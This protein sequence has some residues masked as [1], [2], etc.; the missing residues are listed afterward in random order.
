VADF[1]ASEK[2]EVDNA[3]GE[4]PR[5]VGLT[6]TLS[7]QVGF[8]NLKM[9]QLERRSFDRGNG[10][11]S[12][13]EDG[14]FVYSMALAS[15]GASAL[16]VHFT[17]FNLPER[18]GVYLYTSDGQAFGPYTG[19][20]PLGDGEFW[21]NTV[22][23][24]YL[25]VQLRHIGP[26]TD[27][28]L[29]GTGFNV[30]GLAHIRPVFLAGLCGDNAS[31]V[32]NAVCDNEADPVKVAALTDSVALMQW[33]SG[34]FVYNCTGGLINDSDPAN[35]SNP[36]PYFLTANHC[37]SKGRDAKSLENFF[38][39][40]DDD[41]N[42]NDCLSWNELAGAITTRTLGASIVSTGRA[43]DYTLLQLSQAA[44]SG[45]VYLGW[46][47]TPVADT[48]GIDLFRVSH[49]HGSPQAY[50]EHTVD[51]GAPTCTS[52]PRGDR[53]YSR[54]IVGATEGGSSGSPVVN[55]AIQIVGQLSGACGTNLN[56]EC[57]AVNNATVDGAFA[58]Y[59]GQVS[60][61]LDPVA[62][63]VSE[64]TEVSCGDSIDNDCDGLVDGA[65]PDCGGGSGGSGAPG[66]A[67]LSDGDCQS[68]SCS[69]GKPSSRTCN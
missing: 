59:F 46:N 48:S 11:I 34:A 32:V 28:D 5:R 67:C 10:T 22:V 12:A 61:W 17:N 3:R 39:Y 44:P 27:E 25:V 1:S 45:S 36:V 31:C 50:S 26:A 52:W 54:D 9:S 49:P 24:D 60:Q 43:A 47:S 57:D 15:P 30:A 29:R 51:A 41:C 38:Q 53:I 33:I 64:P 8:G 65:D 23:G 55:G 4:D 21:S 37:I 6:K 63:T 66:D 68:N 18:T 7:S 16:R 56:D 58:A 14:G 42:S 40:T 13:T 2:A 35:D 69:K 62:C 20:G 19:R